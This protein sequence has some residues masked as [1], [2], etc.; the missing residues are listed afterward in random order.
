MAACCFSGREN[1]SCARVLFASTFEN[2][3]GN[4]RLSGSF[5]TLSPRNYY[6]HRGHDA[7]S[8]PTSECAL[9]RITALYGRISFAAYNLLGAVRTPSGYP[10]YRKQ[11]GKQIFRYSEHF[12]P[13]RNTCPMA[14]IGIAGFARGKLRWFSILCISSNL[15]FCRCPQPFRQHIS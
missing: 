7:L 15:P 8:R 3:N 13:G 11:R 12:I 10:R 9:W 14:H 6:L 1:H 5:I 2:S 4:T